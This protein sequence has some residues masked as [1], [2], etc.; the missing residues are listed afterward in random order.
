[1]RFVHISDLHIGKRVYGFSMIEDQKY[2]LDQI[3]D[4]IIREQADG[5]LLAGDIYDKPIPTAEAVQVL[6]AFLTRLADAKIQVFAISGNHD[7]AERLAFGSQLMDSRGVYLS[8]VYDGKVKQILLEDVYGELAV[9]LLPFVKPAVVRHA[10]EEEQIESY[11]DAVQVAISH[12]DVDQNRRNILVAHQF[13][14]GAARCDSEE[15]LVGGL[16]NISAEVLEGFDYVALGHIHSPQYVGAEQIRY[17]GTPLKYSFSEEKQQKSVTVVEFGAK[18]DVKIEKI[19]LKP[20]RDMRTIK[21]T[22]L[23]VTDL[24]MQNEGSREDYVQIILTDEEDILDGLQ[25]LQVIYPNLM[26]LEYDNTRTRANQSIE[27]VQDVEEK[28]EL[29]LFEEFYEIQNNQ[30]MNEQQKE[31][32]TRLLLNMQEEE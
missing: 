8:S 1:M 25:K 32:V 12:M 11:E 10:W 4:I 16:D 15:V 19:P 14:T 21:G 18:G 9:H 24:S 7:S 2:I 28:S 20:L 31:F 17:S 5:V 30:S 13:V 6:D 22:Y 29:E 27:L 3:F 26:H 23:E